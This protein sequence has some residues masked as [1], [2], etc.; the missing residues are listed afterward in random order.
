MWTELA[1]ESLLIS[2]LFKLCFFRYIN[3][4]CYSTNG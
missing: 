2:L 3:S 4:K 1:G